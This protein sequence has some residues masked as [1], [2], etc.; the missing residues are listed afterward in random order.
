M[1]II[2][3]DAR[4]AGNII[5]PVFIAVCPRTFCNSIGNKKIAPNI[6]IASNDPIITDQVNIKF[7]NILKSRIGSGC[8]NSLTTK[9]VRLIRE[10]MNNVTIKGEFHPYLFPSLKARSIQNR[11]MMEVKM[12]MKSKCLPFI[13]AVSFNI[14]SFAPYK[15]AK[16][17]A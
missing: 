4:A 5:S 2:I 1:G 14:S 13:N 16:I 3:P 12:P 9:I 17:I 11:P 8:C 15:M 7:L 10:M 6:P